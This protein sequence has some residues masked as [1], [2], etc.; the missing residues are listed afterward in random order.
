MAFDE[1]A[2]SRIVDRGTLHTAAA[3]VEAALVLRPLKTEVSISDFVEPFTAIE[4]LCR[5][6]LVGKAFGSSLAAG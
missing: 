5:L 3:D 4:K 2:L 1:P 6:K